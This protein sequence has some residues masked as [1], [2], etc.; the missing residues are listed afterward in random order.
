LSESVFRFRLRI[1]V[2][3]SRI[4]P[5]GTCSGWRGAAVIA[6]ASGVKDLDTSPA[7]VAYIVVSSP[8]ATEEIRAAGREIRSLQG[9]PT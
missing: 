7:G 8:P 6:S 2:F 9:I 4:N 1:N 5:N 3:L